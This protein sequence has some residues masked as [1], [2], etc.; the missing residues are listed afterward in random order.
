MHKAPHKEGQKRSEVEAIVIVKY[1]H[2][3]LEG[4]IVQL[5]NSAL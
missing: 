5:M 2:G 1:L 3:R 4:A